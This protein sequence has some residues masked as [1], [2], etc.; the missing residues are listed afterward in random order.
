MASRHDRMTIHQWDGVSVLDLGDMDIWDGADLSL[1][2]DTLTELIQKEGCRDIGV[3]MH[4]V[5]YVPSG[6]FGM[7]FDW[8]DFGVSIRVYTP[9]PNVANM[10]WFRRFFEH[11]GEGCF[12]LRSEPVDAL[13]N[14]GD[15]EWEVAAEW[16]EDDHGDDALL[17][18]ETSF[19]T[20]LPPWQ[21]R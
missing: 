11:L 20:T 9:Q 21:S 1:L 4:Q 8:H 5:K 3:R 19:V 12:L 14:P 6:F 18:E 7:L 13:I 10:L 2:R 17:S 15:A 16:D